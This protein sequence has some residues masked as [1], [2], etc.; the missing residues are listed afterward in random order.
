M[1]KKRK[2]KKSVLGV[3]IRRKI[4]RILSNFCA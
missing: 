4:Q 2:I 3:E 1:V